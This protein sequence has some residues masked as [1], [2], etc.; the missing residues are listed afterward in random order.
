[1]LYIWQKFVGVFDDLQITRA[2]QPFK[3]LHSRN[4]YGPIGLAF[5]FSSAWWGQLKCWTFW[6]S[7]KTNASAM[8]MQNLKCWFT[9]MIRRSSYV[10]L[11]IK[12]TPLLYKQHLVKTALTI[13]ISQYN[14]GHLYFV[15]WQITFSI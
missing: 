14:K 5:V 9:L 15:S 7:E 4:L 11:N 10:A 13:F 8:W 12:I 1:M 3:F 6:V 2:N